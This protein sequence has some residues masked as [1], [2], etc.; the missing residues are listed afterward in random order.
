MSNAECRK[1]LEEMIARRKKRIQAKRQQ[2]G[3]EGGFEAETP[4]C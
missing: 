3:E 2:M 1:E 4:N